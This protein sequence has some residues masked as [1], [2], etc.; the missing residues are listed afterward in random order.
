MI[1][2]EWGTFLFKARSGSWGHDT[3]SHRLRGLSWAPWDVSAGQGGLPSLASTFGTGGRR[4]SD[5]QMRGVRRR[6]SAQGEGWL[7]S[8]Y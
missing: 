1:N 6:A 7:K 5:A 3:K 8:N 4:E 2:F